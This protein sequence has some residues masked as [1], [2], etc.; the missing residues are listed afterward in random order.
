MKLTGP[1]SQFHHIYFLCKLSF[2]GILKEEIS[3]INSTN[4]DI[5]QVL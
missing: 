1:R 5:K 4:K 3:T 2:N